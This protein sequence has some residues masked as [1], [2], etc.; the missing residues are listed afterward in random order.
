MPCTP[1][2]LCRCGEAHFTLRI[3]E[4]GSGK[5]LPGAVL[6]LLSNNCPL[7]SLKSGGDGLMRFP[8]MCPGTYTLA[9]TRAPAGYAPH[10]ELPVLHVTQKGN[11][12]D[13]GKTTR[14]LTVLFEGDGAMPGES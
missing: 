10:G 6:M 12:R 5:A 1:N 11:L 14:Q 9:L 7:F 4:K 13:G 2:K 3:A 8:P